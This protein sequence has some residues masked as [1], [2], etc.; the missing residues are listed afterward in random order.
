MCVSVSESTRMHRKLQVK[1]L[2]VHKTSN[3]ISSTSVTLA[4]MRCTVTVYYYYYYQTLQYI[5]GYNDI[6]TMENY[7]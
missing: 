1:I 2:T 7:K 3:N 6:N 4:W 5:F